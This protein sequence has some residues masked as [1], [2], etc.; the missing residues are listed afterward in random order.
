MKLLIATIATVFLFLL[1]RAQSVEE[2][3]RFPAPNATQAV[4]VDSLY[5]YTISNAKIVKRRKS[6]GEVLKEWEGPLHHLNS[7]IV[8]D[9]G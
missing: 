6:D 2:L 4:P 1:L 8:L 9:T 7:G 3:G 5:F